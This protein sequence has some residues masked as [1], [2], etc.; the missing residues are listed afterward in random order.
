MSVYKAAHTRI[1]RIDFVFNGRR[2]MRSAETANAVEA[3]E[4]E[5][6]W[7]AELRRDLA[8]SRLRDS[9]AAIAFEYLDRF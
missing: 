2:Y 6:R 5:N 7:K 3:K 9:L 8:K 1:Y 4:A